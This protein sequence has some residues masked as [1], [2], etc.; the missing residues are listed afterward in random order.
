MSSTA[1][2]PPKD[3]AGQRQLSIENNG[4]AYNPNLFL[5]RPQAGAQVLPALMPVTSNAPHAITTTGG[6]L[7]LTKG[8]ARRLIGTLEAMFAT[9]GAHFSINEDFKLSC[10]VRLLGGGLKTAWT[11]ICDANRPGQPTFA[12]FKNFIKDKTYMPLAQEMAIHRSYESARPSPGERFTDF[13]ARVA[14]IEDHLEPPY[15]E[16]H[17]IRHLLIR[18]P[19]GMILGL[20]GLGN[21]ETDR[22]KFIERV[23]SLQ[24]LE[25]GLVKTAGQT[26]IAEAGDHMSRAG[27]LAQTYDVTALDATARSQPLTPT[28]VYQP[29]N[30]QFNR[31]TMFRRAQAQTPSPSAR[32]SG[33]TPLA[34]ANEQAPVEKSIGQPAALT[35]P[36][37][38]ASPTSIEKTP[39]ERT[40]KVKRECP[41]HGQECPY[42][43]K[44]QKKSEDAVASGQ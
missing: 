28:I 33:Q 9:S 31:Q 20:S 32:Q 10:A 40:S 14:G 3:K 17:R 2:E 13:A 22:N 37:S 35:P 34:K 29:A 18:V 1:S 42:D 43:F 30:A 41:E 39:V 5:R 25:S 16:R 7:K 26:S 38:I 44:R 23:Q 8:E 4:I 21:I 6:Q 36:T 11:S 12:Q 15:S 24:D 27:P 19:P